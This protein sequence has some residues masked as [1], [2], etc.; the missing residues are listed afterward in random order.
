MTYLGSEVLFCDDFSCS[1]GSCTSISCGTILNLSKDLKSF[2]YA[3]FADYYDQF[4]F[5]QVFRFKTL[6]VAVT[7]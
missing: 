1:L 2:T 4:S 3:L 6:W 5:N 7:S